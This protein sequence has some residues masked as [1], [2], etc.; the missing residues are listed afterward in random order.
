[1][2][3]RRVVGGSLFAILVIVAACS[4]HEWW[5][6]GGPNGCGH[7]AVYRLSGRIGYIGNCAALVFDHA[8]TVGLQVGDTI[9]VH[10]TMD[11]GADHPYQY[12]PVSTS[13]RSV[14]STVHVRTRSGD[15]TFKAL[16]KGTAVLSGTGFCLHGPM[17]TETSKV[18]C[19][20]LN[21]RVE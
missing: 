3:A 10:I 11:V 12:W 18:P 6:F 21:I 19:P 2:K 14:V 13:D 17:E 20:L 5:A 16:R 8:E 9:D 4:S 1:M 15:V 7:A